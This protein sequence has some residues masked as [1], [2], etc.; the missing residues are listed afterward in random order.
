MESDTNYN[1]LISE[2]ANY[3]ES[4]DDFPKSL[5]FP[6]DWEGFDY[7]MNLLEQMQA[8]TKTRNLVSKE[9]VLLVIDVV[10]AMLDF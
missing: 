5:G 2:I 4:S 8:F 10:P 3:I 7:F 1:A 9:L 6:M